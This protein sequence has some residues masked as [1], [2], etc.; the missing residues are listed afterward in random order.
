MKVLKTC[1][2]RDGLKIKKVNNQLEVLF[3]NNVEQKSNLSGT[4]MTWYNRKIEK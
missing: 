3:K 4:L 1:F 2:R